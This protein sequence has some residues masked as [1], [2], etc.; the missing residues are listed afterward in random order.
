MVSHLSFFTDSR[1]R[2]W[3]GAYRDAQYLCSTKRLVS[4]DDGYN[5]DDNSGDDTS[6]NPINP[7]KHAL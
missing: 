2:G 6:E 7:Y 3:W 1:E 5:S 4:K